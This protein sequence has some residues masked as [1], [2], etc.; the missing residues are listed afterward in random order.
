MIRSALAAQGLQNATFPLAMTVD[1]EQICWPIGFLTHQT[2]ASR[3]MG[4]AEGGGKVRALML[5]SF[6]EL[7]QLG[8]VVSG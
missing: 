3:A 8:P 6:G 4:L 1:A 7:S 5:P 2:L